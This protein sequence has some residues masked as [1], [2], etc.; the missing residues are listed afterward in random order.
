VL[1]N[2]PVARLR[3]LSGALPTHKTGTS[4]RISGG[5]RVPVGWN[6][7]ERMPRRM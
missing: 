5:W 1:E 4:T 2:H 3:S 7:L 6:E